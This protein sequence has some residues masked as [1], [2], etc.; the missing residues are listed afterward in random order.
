MNDAVRLLWLLTN[1][2]KRNARTV[3]DLLSDNNNLGERSLYLNLGYW[4]GARK[5]DDACEALAKVLAEAARLAPGDEVL[6]CGFGFGDQDLY[7][8]R[9]YEI[10]RIVGLNI[11]ASQVRA[12]RKRV[13][14][15][16]LDDRVDLCEGSATAMPL[17][18]ASFNKVVALETAFHYDTREDFFREAFRVL[19]PGGRLATADI[20]PLGSGGSAGLRER[21]ERYLNRSFWQIPNGNMYPASVYI[22]KLRGAGFVNV[23]SRSIRE[24][25]YP[26]FAL[27]AKRRLE[28]PEIMSR[29]KPMVRAFWKISV[30][31][32]HSFDS[33]DYVIVSA[34]KPVNA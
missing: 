31:D 3:Y 23:E 6:D 25:V 33:V 21:L 22:E 29:M 1:P 30:K 19:K 10:R 9:A 18:D 28:E 32:E 12:A 2:F 14:E 17:A 8:V 15:L 24:K 34:D 7:W 13:I 11:T 26:S 5:Y 16:G 20:L 27:Y 4:D